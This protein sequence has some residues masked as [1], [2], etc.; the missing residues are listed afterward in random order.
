VC[1]SRA[2]PGAG[3]H[4]LVA[5]GTRSGHA[6]V[7]RYIAISGLLLFTA[8][9]EDPVV[10]ETGLWRYMELRVAE[11]T[12]DTSA[13]PVSGDFQITRA[14]E[15]GFTVDTR[16]ENPNFDCSISGASYDCQ[17]QTFTFEAD[18]VDAVVT[19]RV[20][21]SGTLSSTTATSGDRT[22]FAQCSGAACST[23]EAVFATSFPCHRTV[24]FSAHLDS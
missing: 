6:R 16:D 18:N 3:V 20:S 22:I 23:V 24:E 8:C 19:L 1:G 10:P 2:R 7:V 14:D 15:D 4:A 12:C 11:D 17:D 5:C 9:G 21:T 13:L